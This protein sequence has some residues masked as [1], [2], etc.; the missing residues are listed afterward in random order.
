ME[1]LEG[2]SFSTVVWLLPIAVAIHELEEWNILG[3]YQRNFVELPP[4]SNASTR[5][6]LV[7]MSLYG[8]AWTAI[9]L[10]F[11]DLRVTAFLISLAAVVFLL[12]ALQHVYWVIAFRTYAPGVIT[13][14]LLVIP[15][16]LFLG[17]V[18]GAQGLLPVWYELLLCIAVIP[19]LAQTAKAGNRLTGM[20]QGINRVGL[21]LARRLG[22]ERG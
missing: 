8:F 17:L 12:N 3:W 10:L 15:V 6:F 11:S 9:A 22:L 14:A 18:A 5:V 19:G 16:I 21:V 20:L 4:M 1:F 2:V 13:S 7:F